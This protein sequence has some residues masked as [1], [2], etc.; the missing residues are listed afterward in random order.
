MSQPEKQSKYS[1]T[2]LLKRIPLVIFYALVLK[3]AVVVLA[4]AS[5]VFGFWR[6]GKSEAEEKVQAT[7]VV[8]NV[9]FKRD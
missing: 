3:I 7:A 2:R 1:P 9:G 4:L 6:W 5:G 8:G